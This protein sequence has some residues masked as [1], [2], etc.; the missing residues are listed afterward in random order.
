ML[1]A[2][3]GGDLALAFALVCGEDVGQWHV[4]NARGLSEENL[5]KNARVGCIIF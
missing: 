3:A 4:P 1:N 2:W 5:F